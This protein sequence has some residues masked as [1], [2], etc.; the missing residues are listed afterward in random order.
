MALRIPGNVYSTPHRVRVEA[1]TEEFRAMIAWVEG[2]DVSGYV[3]IGRFGKRTVNRKFCF[4]DE[5][6]AF[7][8]KMRWK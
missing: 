5:N 1:T 6:A 8:F 4:S 7:A 2:V 3:Y